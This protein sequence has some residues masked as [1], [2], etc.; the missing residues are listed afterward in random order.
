MSKIQKKRNVVL[1]V[2]ILV[3]IWQGSSVLGR[4]R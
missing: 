3:W 4:L 2:L 1:A